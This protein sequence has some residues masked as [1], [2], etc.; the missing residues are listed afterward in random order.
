MSLKDI[1]IRR[2]TPQYWLVLINLNH[3][4]S[5][6][7]LNTGSDKETWCLIPQGMT[8]TSVDLLYS[9]WWVICTI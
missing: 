7:L 8:W 6:N 2:P 4:V 3:M 9:V 1:K 5:Q